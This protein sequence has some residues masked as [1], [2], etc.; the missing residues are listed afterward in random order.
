[1]G[2]ARYETEEFSFRQ[3]NQVHFNIEQF[4]ERIQ[5]RTGQPYIDA[6]DT[7]WGICRALHHARVWR[8]DMWKK[9]APSGFPSG[10]E[11]VISEA[12]FMRIIDR[13][14]INVRRF[15]QNLK[16]AGIAC[17]AV[18]PPHPRLDHVSIL[19]GL[20]PELV[21]YIDRRYR[22]Y[23]IGCFA[24]DGID[25]VLPPPETY[26]ANGFLKADFR[27]PR[28]GDS[29]HANAEFGALMMTQVVKYL[30]KRFLNGS[31][32]GS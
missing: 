10:A 25:V 18:A 19:Q 27:S 3:G 17:F 1:M 21:A 31:A 8:D 2:S 12:V 22:D 29:N 28:S 6:D 15:M 7:V 13:D 16:A 4:R 23:A 14:F 20:N 11:Q 5:R 26:D 24:E 32:A 30:N 9:Y